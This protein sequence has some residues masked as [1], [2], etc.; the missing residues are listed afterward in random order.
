MAVQDGQNELGVGWSGISGKMKG[1]VRRA[2]S[3]CASDGGGE[4]ERE[5]RREKRER[6]GKVRRQVEGRGPAGVI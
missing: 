5:Q 2:E 4:K 3:Q 1:A 6:E